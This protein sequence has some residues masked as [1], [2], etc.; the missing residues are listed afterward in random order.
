MVNDKVR[1]RKRAENEMDKAGL[2]TGGKRI[3]VMYSDVGRFAGE[4]G[5]VGR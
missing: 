3:V 1:Q 5:E 2:N 4:V